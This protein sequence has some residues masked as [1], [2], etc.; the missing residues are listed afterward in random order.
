MIV[1]GGTIKARA[2]AMRSSLSKINMPPRVSASG[3]MFHRHA[4][5]TPHKRC[6]TAPPNS[7]WMGASQSVKP[8]IQSLENARS[9]IRYPYLRA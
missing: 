8:G 6:L 9:L 7:I 5:A 1:V 4:G 3:G 2:T